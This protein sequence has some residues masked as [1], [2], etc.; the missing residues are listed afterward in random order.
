MATALSSSVRE[1]KTPIPDE[2]GERS[3]DAILGAN[4]FVGFDRAEIVATAGHV[5]A[6]ALQRPDQLAESIGELVVGLGKTAVGRFEVEPASGDRRFADPTWLEH[7]LYRRWMQA[8]LLYARSLHQVIGKLGFDEKDARRAE[9]AVTLLTEALAPTNLL[10]G[11]PAAIKRAF[12]SGGRSLLRGFRHWL[13]DLLNNGGMPS[14]VDKRPFQVGKTLATTPGSIVHRSE[15][16]ELI[17]YAS[18]TESARTRPLLIVPPQI[19]KYYILD[20]APGRS[21]IEHA[22]AQ[23]N[24]VF[25]ISWRNP[26][27]REKGWDLATY[28]LAIKQAI[29]A[30]REITG[31]ADVNLLGVCAG[32]ITT[33]ILLGHL[34]A[35]GDSRVYSATFLVTVLDTEVPSIMGMFASERAIAA[36]RRNSELRGILAGDELARIFAW[37]RPNDLVWNY[38]VNNYLMWNEP[39]AFD[40]LSWNS[41]STNLPAALHSDFLTLFQINPLVKPGA[42]IVSSTPID[43]SKVKCDTYVVGALTDHITPWKACFRTPALLGGRSR[44]VLSSSGHI[45]ALVNPTGN[46]KALYM[47]GGECDVDPDT[48]L[49]GATQHSGSWWDHWL[50]WL[51]EHAGDATPAPKTQGSSRHPSLDPAPGRYVHQ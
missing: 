27:P 50:G 35:L 46:P 12:E 24:Q 38:W 15:V 30:A 49:K 39:P 18:A 8:Y 20:L 32:G 33:A 9:F 3:A 22:V 11:N 48:W 23:G 28:I 43:L 45:Q 14:Q 51:R 44:F 1:L 29:D 47:T 21:L 6:R 25:T 16:L 34:A 7:P 10:A 36:A 37:L 5:L 42:L 4:P 13:D 26:T 19:N 2:L 17:Q 40:I 31:S 41:D